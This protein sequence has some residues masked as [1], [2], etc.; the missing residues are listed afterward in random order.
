M[1]NALISYAT[2]IKILSP[3][4]SQMRVVATFLSVMLELGKEKTYP[5]FLFSIYLNDLE[6]FLNINNVSGIECAV[7]TAEVYSYLKLLILLYADDTVIFSDSSEKLQAALNAFETYCTEWKL[8]V[9]TSKT[10]IVIFT[11]GNFHHNKIFTFQKQAIEIVKEYKYLG[12]F[13]GRTG[14][15]VAA[16]K[17]ITEQAHK[18][19][20]TL[21]KKIRLLDL[22]LDIQTDLFN[23]IIKPILLYGCEL[24][25]VGNIESIE[26]VQLKFYK[27]TLGLK[28]STPS[29]MIYGELGITPLDIDIHT[30]MVSFWT[31]LVENRGT[32]KLASFVYNMLSE[33][34]NSRK[35]KSSWVEK[36]KSLLCSLGFSAVW[37]SQSFI[38]STWLIKA[39]NQKL[40]DIFIQTW[41]SKIEIE[42]ESNVYRIF[43]T[44]FE[45]SK[46]ITILSTLLCKRFLSFRTRN[47]K[48]P[49]ETG[50][51]KGVPYNERV[52]NLCHRDVGDEFHMV[53]I[54]TYFKEER[55]KYIKPYFYRNPNILK[56][57]QLMN[58]S[59]KKILINLCFFVKIISRTTNTN[60]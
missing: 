42:S 24:W 21:L 41:R 33:M 26:R 17:H 9:N 36:I 44:N 23:K 51:W 27:Q 52:C 25:G 11:K 53:L 59:E 48:L 31:K 43:K 55:S 10:K 32:N 45:E 13:S 50:R 54:C 4:L 29:N 20:Y 56:F 60:L 16:I 35:I 18:A 30:R 57:Q 46:Y 37:Y 2:C 38:N 15:Y 7:N 3:K 6:H 8:H 14:S 1:E 5:P 34:H 40:K 28:K 58:T 49:V 12:I 47:H 22:P 39:V 19:V